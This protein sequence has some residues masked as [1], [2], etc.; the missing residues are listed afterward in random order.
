MT[1]KANWRQ[2]L[3]TIAVLAAIWLPRSRELDRFVTI[4]EP[5][6]MRRSANFYA[7]LLQGELSF[8]YQTHHPGVMVMWAGAAAY[9]VEYP[10]YYIEHPDQLPHLKSVEPFLR[11]TGHAP[12]DILSTART[13][14]VLAVTAALTLAFIIALRLMGELTAFF[15]FLLIAFDPFHIAHS[16]VLQQDALMSSF[17]LLSLVA[18]LA[19]LHR[20]Q[21]RLDLL[22]SGVSAGLAWLT[23][24]PAFFLIPFIALLMLFESWQRHRPDWVGLAKNLARQL[25]AWLGVGVAT[26][27]LLW[28]AMWV[29][30]WESVL[31]IFQ[32]ALGAATG[33]HA[34]P[35]FFNGEIALGDPGW[36]FYPLSYL[37]RTSPVVLIG[38]GLGILLL[39]TKIRTLNAENRAW[40]VSLG[41]FAIAFIIFQSLG[42]KK[43]D[44]YVLPIF[45]PLNLVSALGWIALAQFVLDRWVR[46]G[47][48]TRRLRALG[49]SALVATAGVVVLI[50][51]LGALSTSPYYLSY[52]N[53]LMGGQER[54]PE[55]MMIGW[56]EGLDEAARYLNE[57]PRV[58][59]IS[60]RSWYVSGPFDYF[61]EGQSS[62]LAFDMIDLND[63]L[64]ADYVVIYIHQWQ[65]KLPS[66]EVLAFFDGLTPEHIVEIDGLSYAEIY[67][68]RKIEAPES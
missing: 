67:D 23:R 32:E 11:E 9:R 65:R 53:P 10:A 56:G 30:P 40:A 37:W 50:Q 22:I 41:L 62:I 3:L 35:I 68:V 44:R 15:G 8:T 47:V 27:F 58:R 38:L 16:R 36:L 48:E 34:N 19:Y 24:S 13:C 45:A 42:A 2:V 28:P 20:G 14:V 55:V 60:V 21:R 17:M 52:Y 46:N 57:K 29:K 7:A 63:I 25:T 61:F 5:T 4:D 33:G 18:M 54:A 39:V 12:I 59:R 6:W 26:F 1:L 31:Q 43:F 49:Q 66:P 51:F 64:S